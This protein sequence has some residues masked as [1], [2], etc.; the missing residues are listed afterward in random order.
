M[1]IIV[2][3]MYALILKKIRKIYIT[4]T[5]NPGFLEYRM[6]LNYVFSFFIQLIYIYIN[7]IN[8]NKLRAHYMSGSADG[9]PFP[10]LSFELS[11]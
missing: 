1:F 11:Q 7:N 3:I 6:T 5:S 8:T 10:T 2:T 4:S 9:K